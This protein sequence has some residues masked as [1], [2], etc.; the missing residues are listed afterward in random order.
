MARALAPYRVVACASPDYLAR[1]GVPATPEDL[2]SHECLDYAFP[3]YPA[4]GLWSFASGD[5]LVEVEPAA[6]LVANDGRA[7]IEAALTGF[8]VIQVGE[9]KV[10]EHLASGRLVRVLAGYQT[11]CRP[12]QVVYASRKLQA[13]KLRAFIDW[14]VEAFA[15]LR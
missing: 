15:D 10:A 4:P 2:R 9:M 3:G 8:G 7:L 14:L 6:R 13:P 11:P 12:L 1:R 5:R